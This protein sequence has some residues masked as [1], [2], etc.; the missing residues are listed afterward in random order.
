MVHGFSHPSGGAA[1]RDWLVRL[2][3]SL[4]VHTHQ[5]AQ[6]FATARQAGSHSSDRHPEDQRDLLVLHAFKTHE[7]DHLPL[8]RH[9]LGDCRLEIAQLKQSH[10]VGWHAYRRYLSM[11]TLTPS[12]IDRRTSFTC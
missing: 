7:Q 1:T 9:Q 12:L 6:L 4:L 11:A 3:R 5:P 2:G 10:R 8:F